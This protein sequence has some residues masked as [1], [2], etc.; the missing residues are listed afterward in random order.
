VDLPLIARMARTGK[1]L[2][3]STGM[4]TLGEIEE[5]V[6]AARDAGAK[7]IALLKCTSAYP[8]PTTDMHLRT[9]PHMVASVPH[10]RRSEI[11]IS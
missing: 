10:G 3:M 1:P 5:A 8:A 4:A 11:S 9:I 2:I 7:E 6:T